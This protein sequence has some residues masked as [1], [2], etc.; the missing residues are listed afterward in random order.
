MSEPKLK[1][2]AIAPVVPGILHWS[3]R[4]DRIEFRSDAY[5]VV[6]PEGTVLIDPLPLE[7]ALVPRLGGVIAICITA[8]FHQ[9]SC[10]RFRDMTGA[11]VWVPEACRGLD[12]SADHRYE[13]DE[14][15]PGGL[16]A[17]HAP[18]PAHL[19]YAF[20][21]DRG[22]SGAA[23]FSGDLLIRPDDD[24]VFGFVP[25]KLVENAPRVRESVRE[26]IEIR[27]EVLLP[28]HGAPLATGATD[29]LRE[30]LLRDARGEGRS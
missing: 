3:V 7:E 30:A 23:L 26:L 1:A 6:T 11:P 12:A 10:W 20:L 4:D 29:A 5:A 16:R 28:A 14:W 22:A 25:D 18:G 27:P 15:L 13:A 19:H 21:L 9:R 2:R 17:L 24:S 8:G